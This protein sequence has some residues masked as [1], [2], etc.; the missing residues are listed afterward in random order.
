MC[1]KK[2][3]FYL[4]GK[5]H[6]VELSKNTLSVFCI[7]LG[8]CFVPI[9]VTLHFENLVNSLQV[10]FCF[11]D[12]K[13]KSFCLFF[14]L[15]YFLVVS[16]F[17]FF[18]LQFGFFCLCHCDLS[19]IQLQPL[20]TRVFTQIEQM[21]GDLLPFHLGKVKHCL[22]QK[23]LGKVGSWAT[24]EVGPRP[25]CFPL[26]AVTFLPSPLYNLNYCS[27]S[28]MWIYFSQQKRRVTYLFSVMRKEKLQCQLPVPWRER[29]SL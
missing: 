27:S 17:F 7:Y 4:K 3:F 28:L 26:E 21:K 24:V 6:I 29:N 2:F 11:N 15:N 14:N 8:V 19:E 25:C 12:S 18:F 16:V 5:N 13:F 20:P 10:L 1:G 23:A 9:N 22:G